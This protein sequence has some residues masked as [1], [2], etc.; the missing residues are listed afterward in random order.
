MSMVSEAWGVDIILLY[1]V[2]R[3]T[4]THTHLPPDTL[5]K[6]CA[7]SRILSGSLKSLNTGDSVPE[8]RPVLGYVVYTCHWTCMLVLH[9]AMGHCHRIKLTPSHHIHQATV[10]CM[11]LTKAY[12]VETSCKQ[13]LLIDWFCYVRIC[14]S[15]SIHQ[16]SQRSSEP[17]QYQG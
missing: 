7:N 15:R 6:C 1:S 13:L 3:H 8:H 17:V 10:F 11:Q 2:H 16:L 5:T 14:S 12:V 4:Q 9:T